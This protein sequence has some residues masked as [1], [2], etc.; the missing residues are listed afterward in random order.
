MV[1]IDTKGFIGTTQYYKGFLGVLYTEGVFY[2][3]D[4]GVSWL[5]TDISTI[6]KMKLQNQEFISIKCKVKDRK[7]RVIYTNGNGKTLYKQEYDYTD[8]E[9]DLG[10]YF[11]DNVL[12]LCSEY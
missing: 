9:N 4:N 6:V 12:M 10:F 1:R 11:T 7:A 8:L 5:I 3:M 2:I